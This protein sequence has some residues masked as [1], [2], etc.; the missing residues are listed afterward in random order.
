MNPQPLQDRVAI[1]TG[2]AQGIGNAIAH[3][4][5]AE[6]AH[7]AIIDIDGEAARAAAAQI[8]GKTMAVTADVSREEEV[9]EAFRQII[10]E[11]G[12]LDILVNNAGIVGTDTPVHDLEV[13][14]WDRVMDI[15]L[16]GTFLCARAAVRHMIPRR[17]GVIVS[18]ASISGKEGNANMSPYSVSK[19]GVMC[20]TKSLAKELLE[21][22]IRVNCVA[23]ALI[24]SPLLD[25]MEEDRVEFLT[26]KIPMGRLGRPEEVAAT[27]LFLVSDESTFATGACFDASGGRATY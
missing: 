17:S 25:G 15:N 13:A 27:I 11:L 3:R 19:A 14:D 22:N 21:H 2:A 20:F 10:D 12:G 9:A 4:L 6:G 16:K 1:V 24:D 7:V 8:G 23:P 5:A 26:S 18:M